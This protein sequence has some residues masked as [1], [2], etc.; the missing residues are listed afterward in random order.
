MKKGGATSIRSGGAFTLI[1][2]MVAVLILGMVLASLYGTWRII[3]TSTEAA[4]RITARAQRARMATATI[5][6][7]PFVGDV[8]PEQ[9]QALLLLWGK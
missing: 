7:A 8:V 6:Q 4:L 1:E 2:V 5:E 3:L 9:H